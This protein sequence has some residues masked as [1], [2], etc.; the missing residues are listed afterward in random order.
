MAHEEVCYTKEAA[1]TK[2]IEVEQQS[3]TTYLR[4][5]KLSHDRSARQ[6]IRELALEEL[7][8]K[9]LLEKAFFE[10]TVAL[11]DSGSDTMPVMKL[12]LFLK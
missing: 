8:H 10:E 6:L 12:S 4:A 5:Y 7:E 9:F 3:F 2:A 1:L 11:H